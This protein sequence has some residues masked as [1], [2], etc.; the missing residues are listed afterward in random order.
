MVVKWVDWMADG[1]VELMAEQLVLMTAALTD[2]LKA[3]E[4]VAWKA[5]KM[6]ALTVSMLAVW[7][8]A[9]MANRKAEH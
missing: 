5:K 8:V 6:A 7:R 3:D 2:D 9:Q 4:K 1:L